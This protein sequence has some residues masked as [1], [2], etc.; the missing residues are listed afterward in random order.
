M[1]LTTPQLEQ[2]LARVQYKPGWSIQVYDG[3]HE[4]QHCAIT[5]CVSDAYDSSQSVTL[6][7]HSMLPPMRDEEAFMEWLLWRI[8]R[9]EV[10]EAREFL[11]LDGRPYSDPHSEGADQDR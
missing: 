6:D 10:H 4:G 3:R 9:I 11:H 1:N 5:T 2:I 8:A 7:V